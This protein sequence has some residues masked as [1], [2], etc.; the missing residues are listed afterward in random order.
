MNSPSH[1]SP[2]TATKAVS[3]LSEYLELSLDK[4]ASLILIRSPGEKSDVRLGDP[5]EP[6]GEWTRCAAL[7]NSVV[8]AILEATRSGF[9]E[10]DIEGQTYRFVRTF[11]RVGEQGAIVFTPA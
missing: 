9:N 7:H 2:D 1:D 11:A 3:T 6:D 8:L 4:G 5:G 10:L